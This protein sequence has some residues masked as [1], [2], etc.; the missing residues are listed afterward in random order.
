MEKD[1]VFVVIWKPFLLD[2][3]TIHAGI[4]LDL[5]LTDKVGEEVAKKEMKG[6]GPLAKAGRVVVCIMFVISNYIY[7]Y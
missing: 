3:N 7:Y 6:K 2:P 1:A 4:P 5:Y